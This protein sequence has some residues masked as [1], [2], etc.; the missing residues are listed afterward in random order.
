[1]N[2]E[3]EGLKHVM[4]A[5]DIPPEQGIHAGGTG[6]HDHLVYQPDIGAYVLVT[7]PQAV[8]AHEA[9]KLGDLRRHEVDLSGEDRFILFQFSFHV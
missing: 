5:R 1:V 7:N 2:P 9:D 3:L 8:K 4:I 6:S